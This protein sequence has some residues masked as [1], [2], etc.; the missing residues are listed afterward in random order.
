MSVL[1]SLDQLKHMTE[2]IQ[3]I[4]HIEKMKKGEVKEE[5]ENE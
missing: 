3:I 2:E 1:K 5:N 4:E